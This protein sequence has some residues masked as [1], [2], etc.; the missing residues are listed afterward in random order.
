MSHSSPLIPYVESNNP[1]P[2]ELSPAL[3]EHL[4]LLRQSIGVYEDRIAELELA[5]ELARNERAPLE[6]EQLAYAATK[7]A[8]RRFPPELIGMIFSN[9]VG[10]QAFGRKEYLS[11][12]HLGGV[13]KSWRN[14]VKTAPNLCHGLKIQLDDWPFDIAYDA[15]EV[16]RTEIVPWLEVAGKGGA[17]ELVLGIGR[18]DEGYL[19]DHG[20]DEEYLDILLHS[21]HSKI[22]ALTITW[23]NILRILL[24]FNRPYPQLTRLALHKSIEHGSEADELSAALATFAGT[25][26]SLDGLYIGCSPRLDLPLVHSSLRSLELEDLAVPATPIQLKNYLDCLPQLEELALSCSEAEN[27]IPDPSALS[28]GSPLVHQALKRMIIISED[29]LEL[30]A[31]VTFPSL[32]YLRITCCA[33]MQHTKTERIAKRFKS[34][35]DRSHLQKLTL[36]LSSIIS[37]ILFLTIVQNLPSESQLQLDDVGI[38]QDR[39]EAHERFPYDLDESLASRVIV[40]S[41]AL[42][43]IVC[44]IRSGELR[45]LAGGIPR[46][47][48]IKLY[49]P[50]PAIKDCEI[51]S[52]ETQLREW[53]F[54]LLVRPVEEIEDMLF[55]TKF[56]MHPYISYE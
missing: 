29:L 54:E 19:A 36:S 8:L 32:E 14:V 42:T 34:L 39:D 5:L 4:S 10:D 53:G 33:L 28:L 16:F 48:L 3:E 30:F 23:A 6:E 20:Y 40:E 26:P 27:I 55:C 18:E 9:V 17:F 43:E 44:D 31:Y 46:T 12:A 38:I 2:E 1:L 47:P 49:V 37:R 45:W 35:I 50:A 41:T 24:K 11:F 56:T 15:R 52:P 13:C 21:P 7:S 22:S 51:D 25:F